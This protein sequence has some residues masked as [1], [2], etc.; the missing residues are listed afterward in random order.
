MAVVASNAADTPGSS[1]D[2][3]TDAN[4]APDYTAAIAAY[5]TTFHVWKIY[6]QTVAGNVVTFATAAKRGIVDTTYSLLGMV[7]V[8]FVNS[9]AVGA[10]PASL[11]TARDNLTVIA[12]VAKAAAQGGAVLGLGTAGG[13]TN[14]YSLLIDNT[15]GS[16]TSLG[17]SFANSSLTTP[18]D[19]AVILAT[20]GVMRVNA[21]RQTLGALTTASLTGGLLG[22][23]AV[24]YTTGEFMAFF[25]VAVRAALT[26]VADENGVV[27]A[28][29]SRFSL[30]S[31]TDQITC[32]GDS[33]LAGQTVNAASQATIEG[34]W[35]LLLSATLSRRVHIAN[36]GKPGSV[37]SGLV[38]VNAYNATRFTGKQIVVNNI[39][40]NDFA[41]NSTA[42]TMQTNITTWV[43]ARKTNGYAGQNICICTVIPRGSFTTA[44]NAEV[45]TYNQWLRDNA[46]SLGITVLD[47]ATLSALSDPNDA[48]YF[49]PDKIHLR[50]AGYAA[51]EAY[52]RPIINGLLAA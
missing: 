24:D 45:A 25:G 21:N 9:G 39:G 7:P 32:Y 35:P 42:A 13:V 2:V 1:I 29:K 12:V 15:Q 46:A 34:G 48:T 3:T 33:L 41:G 27:A 17:N 40:S 36:L 30:P 11:V 26:V 16:I 10:W 18:V 14:N 51:I 37:Y 20:A 8:L 23:S 44:Q 6:D 22:H 52:V 50:K 47:I 43:N 38:S 4:G 19:P 31:Y 49:T 28:A 5:G